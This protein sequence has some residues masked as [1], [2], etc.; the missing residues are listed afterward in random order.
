MLGIRLNNG[1]EH[2]KYCCHPDL[3]VIHNIT[4][5]QGC[6]LL[7]K[8][9]KVMMLRIGCGS[10][11]NR[12]FDASVRSEGEGE[13][14]FLITFESLNKAA[15]VR[16]VV[17]LLCLQPDG[18][19]KPVIVVVG[20]MGEEVC[21]CCCS[22]LWH[23]SAPTDAMAMNNSI[24]RLRAP[25]VYNIGEAA[26]AEDCGKK[27]SNS[28]VNDMDRG[29]NTMVGAGNT[30]KVSADKR[31]DT[32]QYQTTWN[33]TIRDDMR[34]YMWYA[35]AGMGMILF[36]SHQLFYVMFRVCVCVYTHAPAWRSQYPH[37][38]EFLSSVSTTTNACSDRSPR[39]YVAE[40]Q[41]PE[42]SRKKSQQQ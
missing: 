27:G 22:W 3:E 38:L 17:S 35:F 11:H 25:V 14:Q 7:R 13:Q 41:I 4:G 32:I 30:R 1:E 31:D 33:E 12:W 8:P 26:K 24:D 42:K 36:L 23:V 39:Y 18:S 28:G 21:L 19:V 9:K 37:A 6:L 40:R 16:P 20:M 34:Q 2:Y 5:S 29:V 10:G 15:M